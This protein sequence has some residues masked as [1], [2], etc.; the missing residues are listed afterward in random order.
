M[1][2]PLP[3][4]QSLLGTISRFVDDPNCP[5]DSLHFHSQEWELGK[6]LAYLD[7]SERRLALDNKRLAALVQLGGE[8]ER[9]FRGLCHFQFKGAALSAEIFSVPAL[10]AHTDIDVL[11]NARDA[12]AIHQKLIEMGFVQRAP[13]MGNFHDEHIEHSS[14]VPVRKASGRLLGDY[15]KASSNGNLWLEVHLGAPPIPTPVLLGIIETDDALR[16]SHLLFALTILDKYRDL[17][18]GTGYSLRDFIDIARICRL[19][20]SN[21]QV[22]EFGSFLDCLGCRHAATAVILKVLRTIVRDDA[23]WRDTVAPLPQNFDWVTLSTLLGEVSSEDVLD[24]YLIANKAPPFRSTK[25]RFGVA[26]EAVELVVDEVANDLLVELKLSA[27]VDSIQLDLEFL[28][29]LDA[30]SNRVQHLLFWWNYRTGELLERVGSTGS[31]TV[32][33]VEGSVPLISSRVVEQAISDGARAVRVRMQVPGER[34][35]KYVSTSDL[36]GSGILTVL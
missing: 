8:L 3:R 24:A 20:E 31:R 17:M 2:V 35:G 15:R 32:A 14:S 13:V 33:R 10:R 26:D 34:V 21:R 22:S 16:R 5:S 9:E 25:M 12:P 19:L 1:Q 36:D 7:C 23:A 18:A 11:T 6:A 28:A 27:P 29:G 4:Y 30:K